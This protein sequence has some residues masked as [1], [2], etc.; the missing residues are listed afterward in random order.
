MASRTRFIAA[1]VLL[2]GAAFALRA[3]AAATDLPVNTAP[4]SVSGTA[5][6]GETLTLTQGQWTADPA[7]T[8]S[9]QWQRCD[10]SGGACTDTGATGS[11][12]TLTDAD[13]G[14]TVRVLETATNDS[15]SA[16]AQSAQTAVVEA[17]PPPPPA[18][19][20]PANAT[21]PAVNGTPQQGKTLTVT[22]GQWTGDPAPTL[23]EQWQR[24]DTSGANCADISGASGS[25]YTLAADDVGK[26]VRVL[27]TAKNDS[28]SASQPSAVTAAV[29]AAPPPPAGSGLF[30]TI[31]ARQCP[32]YT[33]ITA[34]RARNNIMESLQDLGKDTTYKAGQ[35]IDPLKEA[36]DQPNCKPLVGWRFTLGTGIQTGVTGPW[37]SLSKVTGPY[38]TDVTTRDSV[39]LLDTQARPVGGTTLPG[40]VTIELTEDQAKKARTSSS[41]W[42]QGG[43]PAD[44][45]LY[46]QFPALYG[47]GALRCAVDNL[48]GDNVEWIQI[49][50]S[51]THV[52][53]YAYYVTPAPT[54][55]T[56]VVTKKV[57]GGSSKKTTFP[58]DGNVSYE[59]GGTFSLSASS[60]S[61]ASISFVRAETRP[62]D[63][64]WRIREIVP[65]GWSLT[66][67]TCVSKTGKSAPATDLPTGVATIK[68]AAG[69]T[70]T[71][72]YTDTNQ[73]PPAQL[74]ISTSV[75][76]VDNHGSTYDAM[77]GYYNPND[78]AVTVPVGEDN[79]VTPGGPDRGQPGTFQP[80]TQE[81]FKVSGIPADTSL[82]WTLNQG[83]FT[84]QAVANASFGTRCT[85]EPPTPPTPELDPVSVSVA[86][87]DSHGD[88]YDATFGFLNPNADD[89][90][91]VPIGENNTLSPG[92]PDRGQP[93]V[94]PPGEVPKAFTVTGIPA[95][96]EATW[97][98]VQGT[99]TH[100]ATASASFE[101]ACTEPSPPQPPVETSGLQIQKISNGGVGTFDFTITPAAG[102]TGVNA[103]A[104]T[105]EEGV[106]ASTDPFVLAPGDY[107]IDENSP[108]VPGG[109]W[110][111][112]SI[113]C[114]DSDLPTQLPAHVTLI[115]DQS[116]L[117]TFTNTIVHSGAIHLS[118]VTI[119]GVGT[120]SFIVAPV[121]EPETRYLLQAT[122]LRPNTPARAHGDDTTNLRLGAY[123]IQETDASAGR[124][125]GAVICNGEQVPFSAS[126]VVVLLTQQTPEVDCTFVN[127]NVPGKD[128]DPDRPPGPPGPP[129]GGG[130]DLI[131]PSVDIRIT[132][133]VNRPEITLGDTLTYVITVVNRGNATAD[134]PVIRDTLSGPAVLISA[135]PSSGRCIQRLP[136]ICVVRALDPGATAKIVVRVRPLRVGT[137]SNSVVTGLADVDPVLK[138]NEDDVK[139]RVLQVVRRRHPRP[140]FI[141]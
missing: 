49:P 83:Q 102:G 112:D 39:P 138:N 27:E 25:T 61:P 72:T 70:V 107:E 43:T 66:A 141:G 41:L 116:L 36:A 5:Q 52:F 35:A 9:D 120:A 94:F 140:N 13:V 34:N 90:V 71:C 57:V 16:T 7:A 44:P 126:R 56:I 59:P 3:S 30:V 95:G 124:M 137:L 84:S 80:G 21:P 38:G 111:V 130:G 29:T 64:L 101:T 37:G 103:S 42:I 24:C 121:N 60:G 77:F 20:P 118:K 68:L 132:K 28:G 12:Y 53:C 123:S 15:G 125:L 135:V 54:A 33:D 6:E 96:E 119:N 8:L 136:L 51:S 14:H 10:A 62:G 22:Q 63:P 50:A 85:P 105:T 47:F 81:G 19:S 82:T 45:V 18:Q 46:Q 129:D 67:L 97:T 26:T 133:T 87:V 99:F 110:S 114:G 91:T 32:K 17:A 78:V 117:C 106:P 31:A 65:A 127:V 109:R 128:P 76:C 93:Q 69:D 108:E 4:P 115:A 86:C 1:L 58:F 134:F 75:T 104:T 131:L 122:T 79:S 100:T 88:T 74:Q 40:A 23:S 2:F 55:G 11:S 113:R 73:P 92:G 89:S 139:D 48:N 98:L